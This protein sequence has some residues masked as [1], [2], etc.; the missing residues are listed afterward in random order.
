[1][2]E[3]FI[4]LKQYGFDYRC[5]A[6]TVFVEDDLSSLELCFPTQKARKLVCS[7]ELTILARNLSGSLSSPTAWPG[8]EG[9]D[10]W[11][12]LLSSYTLFRS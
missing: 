5:A 11:D 7:D 8:R 10:C 9:K 12:A 2:V 3:T 1:M 6:E 4:E